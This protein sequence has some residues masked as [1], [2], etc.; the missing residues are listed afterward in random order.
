MNYILMNLSEL[1]RTPTP[2]LL[3]GF[4]ASQVIAGRL[5]R[6]RR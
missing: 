3:V 2:Y 1:L 5:T 4:F 6:P